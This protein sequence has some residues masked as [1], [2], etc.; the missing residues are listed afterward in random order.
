MRLN[1]INISSMAQKLSRARKK[2]LKARSSKARRPIQPPAPDLLAA[3]YAKKLEE[4]VQRGFNLVKEL[5][6]PVLRDKTDMPK[7]IQRA[8]IADDASLINTVIDGI[9]ERYFG[10]MFSKSVPNTVTYARQ[11]A[12]KLV[13]PMQSQVDRFNQ[14]QFTKQFKRISGV[15]PLQFEPGLNDFLEVTGDQNVNKIVTLTS[16]Y[17]DS[18]RELTND[19]LREGKS[20]KELTDQIIQLTQDTGET[21]KV[22]GK[23]KRSQAHLI[24][25]DQVQKLN[26]DLESQ[27]QQNNGITR[28]IWRTRKNARVRSKANS[29]GYSDHAG[30]EGAV[31]DWK[32]SPVTVLKGKRAGE[33]N[34]AGK[35]IHCK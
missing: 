34:H 2:Q 5:L 7:T 32:F 14:N 29:S 3:S 13:D 22:D 23:I 17:F 31:I 8:D 25:I 20:V 10:G 33:R 15:D 11:V 26:A 28:Y 1:L 30:L 27:R 16:G 19:A 35:D 9:L 24:A 21:K 6:F 18:I 4:E 12:K